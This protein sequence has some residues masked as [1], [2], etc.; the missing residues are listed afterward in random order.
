MT[1]EEIQDKLKQTRKEY[2]RVETQYNKEYNL[3]KKEVLREKLIRL[4]ERIEVYKE[5]LKWGGTDECK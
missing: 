2:N 3:I 4:D 1:K 5:I